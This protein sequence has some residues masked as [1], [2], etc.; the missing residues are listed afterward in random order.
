MKQQF[1]GHLKLKPETDKDW[2]LIRRLQD[3]MTVANPELDQAKRQGVGKKKMAAIAEDLQFWVQNG[4]WF[5]FPRAVL[6]DRLRDEHELPY[7]AE[8]LHVTC[9]RTID[10]GRL[11]QT[12]AARKGQ[13]EAIGAIYER[14][15]NPPWGTVL[16]APTGSGKTVMGIQ[17][18]RK[19]GVSTLILVHKERLMDQWE[20][21]FNEH[22][23]KVKVGR[24]RRDRCDT[25]ETHDV[26]VGMIQSLLARQ[27]PDKFYKS[28]GFLIT[29]EVHRMGAPVWYAAQGQF[30]ACARLGLTATPK[31]KDGLH[32]VFF[33]GIGRIGHKME[34]AD[35][36]IPKLKKVNTGCFVPG[37]KYIL[38]WNRKPNTSRLA[39][40]LVKDEARTDLIVRNIKQAADADRKILVLTDRLQHVTDIVTKLVTVHDID[41]SRYVGGMK[42]DDA[43][44]ALE[45]QVIVATYQMATEGL[46]L[47][48]LD[49]LFLA[50]PKSSVTQAAGRIRRP[51]PDKKEPIIVDFVDEQITLCQ[52]MFRSRV[53][54]YRKIG[55]IT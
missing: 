8:S 24:V 30:P 52:G 29:D 20:E 5:I 31:R 32:I 13:E 50:T 16:E 3:R 42:K 37:K 47:P 26:V 51:H 1:G 34:G 22:L 17:L 44:K 39:N 28:F 2:V 18:Y 4:D 23:P 36:L 21:R 25:G 41:T 54:Q 12:F 6:E 40:A 49:T 11:Q 48:E 35:I 55:V 27:Y 10:P 43:D 46:D 7:P 33:A 9:G 53:K 15:Q 14:L 38:P 45:S 19:V